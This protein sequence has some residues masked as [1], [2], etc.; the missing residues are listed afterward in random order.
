MRRGV[1]K[2][3]AIAVA[4]GVLS[5]CAPAQ[6]ADDVIYWPRREI[7]AQAAGKSSTPRP[8]RMKAARSI[9]G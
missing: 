5:V 8:A 2:M 6:A 7:S 1:G 3:A 9:A 4:L